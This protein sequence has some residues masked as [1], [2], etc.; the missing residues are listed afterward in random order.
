MEGWGDKLHYAKELWKDI[1]N[2]SLSSSSSQV[3][4]HPSPQF[5]VSHFIIATSSNTSY[6]QTITSSHPNQL[7]QREKERFPEGNRDG[8]EDNELR[9]RCAYTC[10][11]LPFH[12]LFSPHFQYFVL[13]HFGFL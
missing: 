6:T 5:G 1:S 4:F 3:F 2:T 10:T 11:T 8:R 12:T 9:W 7:T 13:C